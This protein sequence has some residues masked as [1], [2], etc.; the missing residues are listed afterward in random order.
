MPPRDCDELQTD[1]L[2]TNELQ[3]DELQTGERM[4][5][6]ST[7][8]DPRHP[9]TR[10]PRVLSRL[11]LD[12]G[13]ELDQLLLGHEVLDCVADVGAATRALVDRARHDVVVLRDP[14]PRNAHFF[15]LDIESHRTKTRAITGR[16]VRLRAAYDTRVLDFPQ[17]YAVIEARREA[18]EETRFVRGVAASVVIVD[19]VGA[20]LD[21]T[22]IDSSG[23][24]SL[25][26]SEPRS[27]AALAR[28]AETQW[29]TGTEM[30]DRTDVLDPESQHIL[31]LLAAGA[32]DA[33]IAAQTG[34]SRRTVERRV[35]ALLRT[36]GAT[37][38]FQAGVIAAHRGWV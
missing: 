2:Q 15:A 10:G 4:P 31:T 34:L 28:L 18:G 29:E 37:T 33:R 24:G 30:V 22:S 17:A 7:A 20:V 19:D 36:C 12:G 6:L 8:T 32:G 25:L 27:L 26:I 35:Q 3:T 11:G 16:G 23:A 5:D 21:F 9:P 38:R 13:A 1:E 14:S